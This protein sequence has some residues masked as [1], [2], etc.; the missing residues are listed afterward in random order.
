MDKSQSI[1][2]TIDAFFMFLLSR[3]GIFPF[4]DRIYDERFCFHQYILVGE[5]TRS[6]EIMTENV[7]TSLQ[8]TVQSCGGNACPMCGKC[9]DWHRSSICWHKLEDATC[10]GTSKTDTD[11]GPDGGGSTRTYVTGHGPA[12]G[13]ETTG[14]TSTR[15][16]HGGRYGRGVYTVTHGTAD[17]SRSH[18]GLCQCK[19][20]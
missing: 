1:N 10:S 3:R 11:G 18:S 15:N 14:T 4:F 2:R 19:S 7:T 8:K 6:C 9:C 20:K 13:W 16:D 5:R 17:T 12:T